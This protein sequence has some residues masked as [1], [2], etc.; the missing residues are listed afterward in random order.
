MLRHTKWI[1]EAITCGPYLSHRALVKFFT[2]SR[3]VERWNLSS[4]SLLLSLFFKINQR[5][6]DTMV[7]SYSTLYSLNMWSSWV[8]RKGTTQVMYIAKLKDGPKKVMKTF[9]LI[10][11]RFSRW[12][13]GGGENEIT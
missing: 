2:L 11:K 5:E 1:N 13:D 8:R 12:Y 9:A 3:A 4:V 7:P 10:W 6:Y